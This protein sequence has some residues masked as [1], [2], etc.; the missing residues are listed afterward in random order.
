[1]TDERTIHFYKLREENKKLKAELAKLKEKISR[2][3]DEK[4]KKEKKS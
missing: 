1:M 3:S 2:G 4:A